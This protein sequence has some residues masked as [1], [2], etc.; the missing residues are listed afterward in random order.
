MNL[1]LGEFVDSGINDEVVPAGAER[2][3]GARCQQCCLATFILSHVFKEFD[4]PADY[5][6]PRSDLMN[7]KDTTGVEAGKSL[8]EISGRPL[9]QSHQ[10]SIGVSLGYLR[11]KDARIAEM[12]GYQVCN[13]VG[14]DVLLQVVKGFR[15]P[16]DGM[17]QSWAGMHGHWY[18]ELTYACEHINHQLTRAKLTHAGALRFVAD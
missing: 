3:H 9:Y 5:I 17:D 6:L 8:F 18:G 7:V 2:F 12:R 14:F 4:G 11:R 13:A 16:F 1:M 10:N 15:V